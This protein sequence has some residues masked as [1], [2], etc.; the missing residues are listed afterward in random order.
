MNRTRIVPHMSWSGP[1]PGREEDAY[2]LAM[3]VRIHGSGLDFEDEARRDTLMHPSVLT[4]KNLP[5]IASMYAFYKRRMEE[6]DVRDTEAMLKLVK[7]TEADA[8]TSWIP[9][10]AEAIREAEAELIEYVETSAC[11]GFRCFG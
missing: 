4:T 5:V 7:A 1:C 6:A 2:L 11:S 8:A 10:N 9:D 3:L